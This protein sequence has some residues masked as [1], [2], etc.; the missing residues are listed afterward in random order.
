MLARLPVRKK[1][2]GEIL[3]AVNVL[4]PVENAP[5]LH[6]VLNLITSVNG[7]AFNCKR[8]GRAFRKLHDNIVGHASEY[9]RS[10]EPQFLLLRRRRGFIVTSRS[11]MKIPRPRRI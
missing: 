9:L 10:R 6:K 7:D 5:I 2:Y 8:W 4:I 11:R 1:R 3:E